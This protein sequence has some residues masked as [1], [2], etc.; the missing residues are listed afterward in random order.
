MM[1]VIV[2]DWKSRQQLQSLPSQTKKN[3]PDGEGRLR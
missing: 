2:G 3:N 1:V